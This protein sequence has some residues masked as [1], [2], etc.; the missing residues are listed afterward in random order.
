M[1]ISKRKLYSSET[2]RVHRKWSRLIAP[3]LHEDADF[4]RKEPLGI[5]RPRVRRGSLQREDS[6]NR[7]PG[8]FHARFFVRSSVSASSRRG[9]PLSRGEH[10]DDGGP[11]GKRTEEQRPFLLPLDLVSVL[12]SR[13]VRGASPGKWVLFPPPNSHG[14]P[15]QI[16][17]PPLFPLLSFS[18][19]RFRHMP[20][21]GR[22]PLTDRHIY[23]PTVSR[24]SHVFG[25]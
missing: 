21:S 3:R 5:R 24:V 11:T 17:T 16:R 1:S 25:E 14:A 7:S 6:E 2:N 8:P 18:P 15:G 22:R 19:F 23:F 9:V 20:F 12:N 10:S 4:P 13:F